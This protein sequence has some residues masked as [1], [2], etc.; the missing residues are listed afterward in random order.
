M[1]IR[2]MKKPLFFVIIFA[3]ILLMTSCSKDGTDITDPDNPK[4]PTVKHNDFVLTV[5]G[6]NYEGKGDDFVSVKYDIKN[7]LAKPHRGS[8]DVKFSIKANDGS[9]FVEA[10]RYGLD[11]EGN[12]TTSYETLIRVSTAKEIKLST[13]KIESFTVVPE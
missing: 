13:F 8:F 9:L 10:T 7:T 2:R 12:I 1:Q 4:L 11:V 6:I 3:G 5:T